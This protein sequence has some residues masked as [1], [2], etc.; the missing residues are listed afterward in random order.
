M[1][2]P[3]RVASG[4]CDAGS[5]SAYVLSSPPRVQVSHALEIQVHR[6]GMRCPLRAPRFCGDQLRP[7]L[8][9]KAR[10]DFVLHVE[11]IGHGFRCAPLSASMSWTLTRSRLPER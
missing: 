3:K 7:Q 10:D 5:Y 6:V 2:W 8:A 11:E 1:S 4:R 9:G